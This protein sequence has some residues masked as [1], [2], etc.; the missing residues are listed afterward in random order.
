[1]RIQ[2]KTNLNKLNA[3]N[4]ASFI[5]LDNNPLS[6]SV[7]NIHGARLAHAE[8]QVICFHMFEFVEHN[9]VFTELMHAK[10]NA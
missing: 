2:R 10:L 3:L 1:L 9:N 8:W 6:L 7:C 5:E 4:A